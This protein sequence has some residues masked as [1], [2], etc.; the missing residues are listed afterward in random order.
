[1]AISH[2][3]NSNIVFSTE[4]DIINISGVVDVLPVAILNRGVTVFTT[5]YIPDEAGNV[6]IYSIKKVVEAY[7]ENV[8]SDFTFIFGDKSVNVRVLRSAIR[9]SETAAGFLPSFFLTTLINSKK[10]ALGRYETLSFYPQE[11]C[12]VYAVVSYLDGDTLLSYDVE[13]MSAD[14]VIL[15]AVNIVN[16]SPSRFVDE[17]RGTLVN[18][19]LHAGKRLFT[20]EIDDMLPSADPAFIFRNNFGCWETFYLTGT[21]ET[22]YSIKRSHAYI[23]GYYKQYDFEDTEI[24]NA[25]SGILLGNMLSLGMDV[26]RTTNVFLL[27]IQ[28]A[29]GDEIVLTDSEIKY[30]NDDDALPTFD[31]TFRRCTVVT[32]LLKTIRPSN[33]F[34]KTFD[35]TFN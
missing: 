13:L 3:I 30:T 27:D 34:D 25:N 26:A 7:I 11:S 28:G 33:L 23:D 12:N 35:F 24:F 31:Y 5:D 9:I 20:L 15:N 8:F 29:A 2:N 18:I 17:S 6:V 4:L 19:V 21:K 22:E 16:V 32:A 1:M 14:D 10:T